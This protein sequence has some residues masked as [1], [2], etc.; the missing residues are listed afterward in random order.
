MKKPP[1]NNKPELLV[2]NEKY[3][4]NE[5]T[6]V[7]AQI[8]TLASVP[9]DAQIFWKRPSQPDTEVKDCTLVDLTVH[10]GPDRF[11]TQSVGSQAG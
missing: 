3:D 1:K 2:D 5:D 10:P 9:D 7:G 4:W 8:R 11:C 6:I